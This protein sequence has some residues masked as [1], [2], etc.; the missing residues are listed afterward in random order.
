MKIEQIAI[1]AV[2]QDP[3]NVRKHSERNLESIKA[4]LR[5]FGQQ[6]PIV[7]DSS[8]IVLAGNGTLEAAK[9]LGWETIGVVRTTLEGID[10][11]A[12]AI[13]DNR[14]AELAEWDQAALYETLESLTA[15]DEAIL[16]DI[17]FDESEVNAM[18]VQLMASEDI[19]DEGESDDDTDSDEPKDDFVTF[20]VPLTAGQ[21]K[22]LRDAIAKAKEVDAV[23]TTADA[24]TLIVSDW[25]NPLSR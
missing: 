3:A 4:S 22:S 12:Y 8:D 13:A 9:S 7:V 15:E 21:E 14:T 5:R 25:L 24:L 1:G 2:S 17:G 20:T 11:T 16:G 19:S 23:E 10:A 18:L 6:K